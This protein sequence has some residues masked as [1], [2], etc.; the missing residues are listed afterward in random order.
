MKGKTETYHS[1]GNIYTS[2]AE[3]FYPKTVEELQEILAFCRINGRRV[4]PAGSFHS[5]DRQNA[6]Q[7][8]VISMRHFDRIEC[9]AE[10]GLLTAGSGASWGAIFDAAYAKKCLLYTCVTGSAPTAGGTLSINSYSMWSPGVGKESNH[11]ISITLMTTAGELV[12]CSRDEHS[13]LF[14]G[15]IAG[16][17]L[18]GFII[19]IT[20]RVL[21]V[22]R[23]FKIK[24][25][26]EDYE[27]VETLEDHLDQRKIKDLSQLEQVKGQGALFYREK[28]VP[29]FTVYNCSYERTNQPVVINGFFR[30]LATL[31]SGLIR[32]FPTLVDRVLVYE[33]DKAPAKRLLLKNL[34]APRYGL[35]WAQPDYRWSKKFSRFF[36]RWGYEPKLYQNSYFI[37]IGEERVTTFTKKVYELIAQYQLQA[38]MFDVLHIPQDELPFVLSCSRDTAGFYVNTTFMEKTN[39]EDLM[40]CYHQLNLL[41]LE[42]AGSLNLSKNCFIQP[43]LLEQM[44]APALAEFKALKEK[45]DPAHLLTSNFFEHY[46]P[47]YFGTKAVVEGED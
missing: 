38:F 3:V 45:Y 5:F 46:F 12:T 31:A 28:G 8:V 39:R 37:P 33:K 25:S 4:T 17:G 20:Y 36:Q 44:Y 1:Y 21:P 47:S 19:D 2:T 40:A 35:F 15:V 13:D 23:D 42:L 43:N 29:K 27:H 32:F 10:Q 41:A 26:I 30:Q 14:L 7:D 22:K 34:S 24:F 11:C 18:L 6:S 9:D 16:L